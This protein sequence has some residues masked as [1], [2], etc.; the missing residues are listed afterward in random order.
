V[1]RFGHG[2]E[3]GLALAEFCFC[4]HACGDV[5]AMSYIADKRSG[6]VIAR[7]AIITQQ[8]PI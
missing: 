8:S 3:Q 6:A 5:Q 2:T 1:S 4:R 7:G